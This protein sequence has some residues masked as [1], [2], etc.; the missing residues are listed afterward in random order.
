[1]VKVMHLTLSCKVGVNSDC[2]ACEL[3]HCAFP[4]MWIHRRQCG[5]TVE[6]HCLGYLDL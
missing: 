5:E 1:M 6:K 2:R 3:H 4:K